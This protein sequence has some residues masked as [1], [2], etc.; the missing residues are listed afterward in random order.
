MVTPR[1]DRDADK[2]DRR[3][4][5]LEPEEEVDDPHEQ[6]RE[7]AEEDKRREAGDVALGDEARRGHHAEE[8]G[9]DAEDEDRAARVVEEQERRE[10]DAGE[11]RIAEEDHP[12][13]GHRILPDAGGEVED[14]RE[15]AD[16]QREGQPG[17][18]KEKQHHPVA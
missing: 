10:R 4:E 14:E 9:H 17:G 11:H 2:A 18:D 8:D 3:L 15:L 16:Q 13:G 12:R 6:Q 7:Q 1:E 5:A